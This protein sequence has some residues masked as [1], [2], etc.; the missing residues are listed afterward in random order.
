MTQAVRPVVLATGGTGGHV[1][2]AEALAG[3]L[4]CRNASDA[5]I[6]E[7]RSLHYQ[8]AAHHARGALADVLGSAG[9]GNVQGEEQKQLDVLANDEMMAM[10]KA[11]SFDRAG[12]APPVSPGETTVSVNLDVVFELGR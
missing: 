5:D 8:M 1:F 10:A 6:A 11:E 3:E 9:T 4:V 12:A 7:I 2:P